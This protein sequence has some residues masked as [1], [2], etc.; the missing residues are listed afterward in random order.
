MKFSRKVFSV[1]M[2]ANLGGCLLYLLS[3][4]A[5]YGAFA[6]V[7]SVAS[8]CGL[9]FLV[10]FMPYAFL[11]A[12][13][14]RPIDAALAEARAEDQTGGVAGG[15]IP[16][17]LATVDRA[18]K[19]LYAT[20]VLGQNL[21]VLVAFA[22]GYSLYEGSPAVILSLAFLREYLCVMAPFLL[23][24]VAQLLAF[25]LIFAKAR[26]RL[27]VESL[28]EGSRFGIG[29]RSMV[30][31]ISLVL[32]VASNML[33][34]AELA[35][36]HVYLDNGIAMSRI[37]FR[38]LATKAEK[39]KAIISMMDSSD[40]FLAKAKA[41]D[42]EV[43]SY[44][45]SMPPDQ[46]PDRWLED[47]YPKMQF[48][49]P[50]VG[51]MERASDDVVRSCFL[52]L[53]VALPLC[54][55]ILALFA[56]QLRRQFAGLVR[57]MG[58]IAKDSKDL[59][60]R[61]PVQSIDEAGQLTDSFNRVLDN[62]QRE[63]DRMREL[64]GGINESGGRLTR[65]MSK[66]SSSVSVLVDKSDTVYRAAAGQLSL[67]R[68]GEAHL[69]GL[70][71]VEIELEEAI[72][73]QNEA[74]K[75]M[76][77]SIDG[78]TGEVGAVSGLS[79]ESEALSDR[80]LKASQVGEAAILESSK[81]NRELMES[82]RAILESL[83]AMRD[84]AERTNLLAMNASIEAAHAGQAGRGFA[85]VAQEIR[86]LAEGSAATV[87]V[88]V[89]VIEAMN[90]RIG[91]NADNGKAVE[92]SFSSILSEVKESHRMS[93][94]IARSMEASAAALATVRGIGSSMSASADRLALLVN[95]QEEKRSLLEASVAKTGESSDTIR[96]ATEAQRRGA[97]EIGSAVGELE[98]VSRSS[99]EAAAALRGMTEA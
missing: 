9:L 87:K 38:G 85:V 55:L 41:Y 12:R 63:F 7:G 18:H 81:S 13:S 91:S 90:G 21:S 44:V 27:H 77:K 23:S 96:K 76:S 60:L 52:Y 54:I 33:T 58:E 28:S 75:A 71:G 32:L 34:L 14:A 22:I 78:I 72:R 48:K 17:R 94:D 4:V 83:D 93:G 99:A 59:G 74:V 29:E 80:L 36:S 79:K 46:L 49:S 97:M 26:A 61:L 86:K 66:T 89:G 40:A 30:A 95:D 2:A 5:L 20:C 64:A 39:A 15:L 68:E 8:L 43:R 6:S 45:N 42:D 84:I 57:G 56:R 19:R 73:E 16:E 92:D 51:A 35:P 88:A 24:S 50:L 70:S 37:G 3:I 53:A 1:C 67:I 62:R 98:E 11:A 25:G 82:S 47:F 65:A 31:G 10:V 69:Q